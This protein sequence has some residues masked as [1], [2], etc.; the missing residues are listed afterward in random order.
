[1][2]KKEV[3]TFVLDTRHKVMAG[4]CKAGDF[5][6]HFA[7]VKEKIRLHQLALEGRLAF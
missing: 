3:E 7:W 2:L 4:S 1:M 6:E 5:R